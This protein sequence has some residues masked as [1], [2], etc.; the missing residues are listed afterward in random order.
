[1]SFKDHFSNLAHDYT[2]YRPH[3]PDELFDYLA[4]LAATHDRAWDC[5]TGNGQAARGLA[6][7]FKEVIATDAS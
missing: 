6:R 5:G 2:K 1:M 4:S 3:Y 7:R